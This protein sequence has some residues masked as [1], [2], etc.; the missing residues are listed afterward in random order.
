[1]EHQAK[2]RPGLMPFLPKKRGRQSG[3]AESWRK[4]RPEK[5]ILQ[6]KERFENRRLRASCAMLSLSWNTG[7]LILY[8]F[9]TDL[10]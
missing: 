9:F 7:K 10:K 4:R 8:A 3:T 2:L 6:G 1:M 5:N